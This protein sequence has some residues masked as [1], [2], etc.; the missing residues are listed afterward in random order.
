M[1]YKMLVSD[2]DGTLLNSNHQLD[3]AI[4]DAVEKAVENGKIVVLATGREY[5]GAAHIIEKLGLNTHLICSNGATIVDTKTGEEVY[6]KLISRD[7]AYKII[8]ACE[9][10]KIYCR[11]N[12]DGVLYVHFDDPHY[13][14]YTTMFGDDST[15]NICGYSDIAPYMKE[16]CAIDQLSITVLEDTNINAFRED[17]N[18]LG[19]T[20]IASNPVSYDIIAEGTSK[21]EGVKFLAEAYN[22]SPEE[23]IAVGDN[24]N[25]I[26]MI[27][28]AGL[29]VAMENSVDDVKK[30]ADLT[31]PSNDDHGVAKL[32][33][34]ILLKDMVSTNE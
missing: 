29:G 11:P 6:S 3:D 4:C 32:I 20:L 18:G 24:Y 16:G 33:E 17:I 7:N 15:K 1:S 9:K 26:C 19:V 14:F 10:N 28:Y 30:E 21:S 23:I 5:C 25:D 27:Q 12:I 8:K 13:T 2:I 34:N 22:I 31:C